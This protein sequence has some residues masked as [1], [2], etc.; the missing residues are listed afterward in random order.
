[1]GDGNLGNWPNVLRAAQKLPITHILPGHGGPAGPEMLAGQIQFFVELRRAVEAAVRDKKKLEDVVTL[2]GGNPVATTIQLPAS[3]KNWAGD[4]LPGQVK[5]AYE[6][7][8]Q[9]RPAGEIL[10]GK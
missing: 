3:V 1:M 4:F 10:G 5:A 8:T 7:I 2:K 9:K 6:E